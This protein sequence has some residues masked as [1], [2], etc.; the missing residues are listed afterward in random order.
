MI[1]D[2]TR[3]PVFVAY[4]ATSVALAFLFYWVLA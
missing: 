1:R 2:L 4:A 3:D